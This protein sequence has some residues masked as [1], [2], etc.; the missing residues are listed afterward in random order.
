MTPTLNEKLIAYLAVLSGL[1]LSVVAEFYSISGL[2]AIFSAATIPII[3][4]GIALGVGKIV[5]TLWL[6]QNWDIAPVS[7]KIYL[8]IAIL[9]LMLITS[10]G[11][12]G[13]LSKAHSDQNLV[14]GDAQAKIAVYDEK[15]KTAKENI[16]VNRKAL[17]QLD[18]A[19]DQVMS[20]EGLDL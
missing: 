6:K 4:M 18:E 2:V 7:V 12:F 9:M 13:F 5:A 10:I 15:I 14:S 8:S 19:V 16:D 17:K 1:T 3:I 11:I 20:S